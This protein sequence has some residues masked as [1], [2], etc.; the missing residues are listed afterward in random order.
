M[1]RR[2]HLV[3]CILQ[4]LLLST[5]C[6]AFGTHDRGSSRL[7]MDGENR[8]PDT[9]LFAMDEQQ[10]EEELIQM[11]SLRG[12][13]KG[14]G[15]P[16]EML[17]VFTEFWNRSFQKA[18]DSIQ[19]VFRRKKKADGAFLEELKTMPIR[20][21]TV[22]NTTVLPPEVVRVAIKRSGM[23]GNPLRTDR[24][25]ELA[26]S[27]KRW[28]HRNGYVLHSVTGA[29]LNADTATAE[30]AVD[31]P[32]IA[33]DPVQIVTVKEMVVTEEGDLLTF[34]QYLDRQA[35]KKAFRYDRIEKKDLN[36]TYVEAN[37]RTNPQKVADALRLQAGRPFQW[38]NARWQKIASSGVFSNILRVSPCRLVDGSVQLQV[39]AT[40]PPPRHLEY[41]LGKSLYTGSWE[42]EVDFEHQNLFGGGEV[43]GFMLRRGTKDSEPSIKLR[44][45]DDRFGLEGG[46][47][48][49]VFSDFLGDSS[50][51]IDS[52]G[53]SEIGEGFISKN[54]DLCF[55]K[56]G[57]VRVQ[58][59]ISTQ[60]LRNSIV[61]TSLERISSRSGIHEKIGS[62]TITLGPVQVPLPF[63]ARSSIVTSL[64]GGAR[65]G[66]DSK[67]FIGSLLP[68]SSGSATARQILPI[69]DSTRNQ[70][71]PPVL[72]LQHTVTTST[73]NLP[74]HE[75]RAIGIATQIR[76]CSPDGP[77]RSSLKGTAELRFPVRLRQ[78]ENA[79][80]VLFGDY[81]YVQHS[82][83]SPYK[84]KQSIGLGFRKVISGLPLKYDICYT[85][86]GKIK[87]MFGLGADFD[88]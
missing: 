88:A 75:A 6:V 27:L 60:L 7:S 20:E 78:I 40:E 56:G 10:E 12:G 48:I 52:N 54:G 33:N 68:Y 84:G 11:M 80:I 51:S 38:N 19:G 18:S 16:G 61:S 72:A 81:F 64:T 39:F 62:S 36:T 32:S 23:L 71:R 53:D 86:E 3:L 46:F 42:G 58:N 73:P 17:S 1:L 29:N 82:E 83:S 44:Y 21:V 13:G 22:P 8:I 74:G 70:R 4:Q 9:V 31:E 85:S 5:R 47:D 76:G 28:Y 57:T 67:D 24:V 25:Q 66:E 45:G 35:N 63:E 49:E 14:N 37:G 65:L 87:T 55:R 50:S 34:R 30:I 77:A 59:P 15:G 69:T 2:R 26:S 41:G 79:G 43:L